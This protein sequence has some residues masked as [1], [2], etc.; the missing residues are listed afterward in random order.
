MALVLLYYRNYYN[1]QESRV[2]I[3]V[4]S[5]LDIH[6][7]SEFFFPDNL[8][9]YYDGRLTAFQLVICSE[10]SSLDPRVLTFL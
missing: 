2:S 3:G 4:S 8:V 6:C 7:S 1:H 9:L 10:L 5:M